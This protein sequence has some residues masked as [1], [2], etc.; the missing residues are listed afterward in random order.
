MVDMQLASDG[1]DAPFLY[2]MIAQDLRLKIGRD[3]HDLILG[4]VRRLDLSCRRR[5]AWR[6]K[7]GQRHPQQWQCQERP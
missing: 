3:G 5:N 2:M 7:G 1:A 6:T 4:D